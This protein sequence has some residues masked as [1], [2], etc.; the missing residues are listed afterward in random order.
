VDDFA[1]LLLLLLAA[2]L[3]VQLTRGTTRAWLRAKFLGQPMASK[4]AR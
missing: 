4:A 1:R 3:F 2:A